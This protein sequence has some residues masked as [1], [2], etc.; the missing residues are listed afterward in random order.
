MDAKVVV[1]EVTSQYL[2]VID[3]HV[4]HADNVQNNLSTLVEA[5]TRRILLDAEVGDDKK[6]N[7]DD[8]EA[9]TSDGGEEKKKEGWRD[10]LQNAD[11]DSSETSELSKRS[12]AR[13]EAFLKGC[14]LYL[15]DDPFP[16]PRQFERD[17]CNPGMNSALKGFQTSE[18]GSSN[19]KKSA[20]GCFRKLSSSSSSHRKKTYPQFKRNDL[21]IRLYLY[22][23]SLERV[24]DA[25]REFVLDLE[26]Q[27]G[28]KTQSDSIIR[29]F[30]NTAGCVKSIRPVLTNLLFTLTCELLAVET[31]GE[32]VTE[33]INRL[34]TDY[35]HTTSFASLAFLSSP[36]KAATTH[37]SPLLLTYFTYLQSNHDNLIR[38]CELES[39][40]AQTLDPTL[41]RTFKTVEFRS[42]GHVLD[43]CR[44]F[45]HY[46]ENIVLPPIEE[47]KLSSL[48]TD[49]DAIKQAL[50]D[51]RRETITVNGTV[52][53]A[54]H[55]LKELVRFLNNA[56]NCQ[57]ISASR[58]PPSR[59]EESSS[60]YFSTTSADDTAPGNEADS[61]SRQG[62]RRH[63][64]RNGK[65][66]KRKGC[67][68]W[69]MIDAMTRRLLIASSRTGVGGDAYFVVK[70]LFG[71][72]DVIVVPSKIHSVPQSPAKPSRRLKHKSQ[73]T[74]ELQ[75]RLSKV[76][77]RCHACYNIY[78][79]GVQSEQSEPLIQLHT[80]TEETICLQG[81]RARDEDESGDFNSFLLKEKKTEL[82]GKR[83]MCVQPAYY[84]KV[85]LWDT[86]S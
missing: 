70:D 20:P 77:I 85:A 42:V 71:G 54:A 29:A 57:T 8:S 56:L 33:A 31:L 40:L 23:R 73:G 59:E 30:L 47:D 69:D 58:P 36:D 53:P 1:E 14:S 78:P 61:E 15:P 13:M 16:S 50:R 65:P 86:P 80:S 37:L 2:S 21:S 74:I 44:K 83:T 51:L 26:T 46:M 43:T 72:K 5:L 7:R 3:P 35:E 64:Q 48:C 82:T 18:L 55:S 75:V 52:L 68:S 66:R 10:F 6:R 79:S 17:D 19:S 49:C 32:Q 39:M 12:V 27:K 38:D 24:R 25:K 67:F 9:A 4:S 41:R 22:S 45:S 63:S 34:C 81:V 76:T 60:D 11:G 28:L 84:E 62:R